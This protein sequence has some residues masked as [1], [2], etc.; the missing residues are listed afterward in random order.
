MAPPKKFKCLVKMQIQAGQA[1]PGNLGTVLGPHGVSMMDFCNQFNSQT[2]DKAGFIIP[3]EMSVFEDR[4]FTF[5]TKTPPASDLIKKALKLAKGSSVPNKEKVGKITRAQLQ[6]IA[7]TKMPDLNAF[8]M[9]AAIN[10]IA[11]TAINMG[12][13]VEG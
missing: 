10:I 9:D 3:V 5:I 6:E 4:S 11:G 7:E 1:N 13:E 2:K 12:V 8:N